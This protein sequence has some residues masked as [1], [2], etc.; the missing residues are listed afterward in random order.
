V[1]NNAVDF[2]TVVVIY[3]IVP[4][5]VIIVAIYRSAPNPVPA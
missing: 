1:T 5:I 3:L 4:L 2:F